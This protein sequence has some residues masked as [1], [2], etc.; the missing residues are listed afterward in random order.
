MRCIL[1]WFKPKECFRKYY[2]IPKINH[3][4]KCILKCKYPPPSNPIPIPNTELDKIFFKYTLLM[5]T[6]RTMS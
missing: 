5:G 2:T 1:N 4:C 3:E 6:N